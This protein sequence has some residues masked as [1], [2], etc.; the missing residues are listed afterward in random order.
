MIIMNNK[1]FTSGNRS[2]GAAALNIRNTPEYMEAIHAAHERAAGKSELSGKKCDELQAHHIVPVATDA[3]LA[4]DLDNI[5]CLTP[6]EHKSFHGLY[7]NGYE[8]SA[9]DFQSFK[10]DFEAKMALAA[11]YVANR[12]KV[13]NLYRQKGEEGLAKFLKF[14]GYTRFFDDNHKGDDVLTFQFDESF[15]F[16]DEFIAKMQRLFGKNNYIPFR[17]GRNQYCIALNNFMK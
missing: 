16:G 1:K 11:K 6:E 7:G 14:N 17:N 4:C 13:A 9:A 3:S 12:A 5:I 8:A 10:N 15:E 2:A